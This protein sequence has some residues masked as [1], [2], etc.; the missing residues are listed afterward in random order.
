[1]NI[2]LSPS[3]ESSKVASVSG[4]EVIPEGN[5]ISE[6]EESGGFFAKLAALIKG[7]SS[8]EKAQGSTEADS[9]G[10]AVKVSAESTDA[11]LKVGDGEVS[12]EGEVVSTDDTGDEVKVAT[13][14]GDNPAVKAKGSEDG[15]PDDAKKLISENEELLGRLNES[16][17]ALQ[18]KDGNALPQEQ[19]KLTGDQTP[20]SKDGEEAVAAN[21]KTSTQQALS[22]EDVAKVAKVA[23]VEGGEQPLVESEKVATKAV[24]KEVEVPDAAKPFVQ[25]EEAKTPKLAEQAASEGESKDTKAALAGGAAGASAAV[26]ASNQDALPEGEAVGEQKVVQGDSTQVKAQSIEASDAEQAALVTEKSTDS[27]IKAPVDESDTPV[28]QAVGAAVAT[29]AI[30][31]SA[32]EAGVASSVAASGT[33]AGVAAAGVV[34]AAIP[35][36]NG[37]VEQDP[38]LLVAEGKQKIPQAPVAQSVQQAVASSQQAS[39]MAQG[40]PVA[41]KANPMIAQMNDFSVAQAM[42]AF[43]PASTAA[44]EKAM[45]QAA[46]GMK[47]AAGLGKMTS[48]ENK[49]SGVQSAAEANFAQQ[50]SQVTGQTAQNSVQGRV[51]QAIAQTPLQMTRS[52]IA[53]EQLAERVQ[54]MMSKNLKNIDI[55]LDPPELGRMQIRMNIG[56]DNATVHFTVANQQARDVIEQS[57]PRLRE[58]LSQQGV[59]LGDTSVQ[60][61]A[62]GQQQNRYAGDEQGKSGQGIGNQTAGNEENLE[63]DVKLDLNVATKRDGIS[64][65]A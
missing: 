57:M 12:E 21:A 54:M 41:D 53:G 43:N 18:P 32:T 49:S 2:N 55:R 56:G 28:V 6:A 59:Q 10:E 25:K 23:K 14:D 63:A 22:E 17:K 36:S 16:S 50:L 40:M 19:E 52:D 35:W 47:A 24:S 65:Y 33:A 31:Q 30:A 7:E 4:S 1:M 3:N 51:E 20:K 5:E 8:P 61:Q 37:D 60:Q 58:M 27:E 48:A 13:T 39:L 62:Q 64:Y 15:E 46:M 29:P 34:A 26:V 44:S 11:L 38:E 45:L 9:E 42:P